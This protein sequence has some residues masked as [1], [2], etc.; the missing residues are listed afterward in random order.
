VCDVGLPFSD[1]PL[2]VTGA[3]AY[4]CIAPALVTVHV[5]NARVQ[6]SAK[7]HGGGTRGRGH[8]QNHPSRCPLSTPF[9]QRTLF[10]GVP[11][12]HLCRVC[13]SLPLFHPLE[14]GSPTYRE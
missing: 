3:Q 11:L 13:L 1:S 6:V 2:L 4:E 7:T 8:R 9:Q 12:A 14:Q 10:R 5:L